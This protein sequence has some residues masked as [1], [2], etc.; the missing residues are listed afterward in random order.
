MVTWLLACKTLQLE[1]IE[2]VNAQ[3]HMRP[4]ARVGGVFNQTCR[5]S[6]LWPML[7]AYMFV[8]MYLAVQFA[9]HNLCTPYKLKAPDCRIDRLD[10]PDDPDTPPRSRLFLTVPRDIDVRAFE[11]RGAG[12]NMHS[13]TQH[14]RF[15]FKSDT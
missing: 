10:S 4:L 5:T 14:A 1:P 8:H 13:N 3:E 9:A 7:A 12:C 11:V 6:V 2:Q 15:S